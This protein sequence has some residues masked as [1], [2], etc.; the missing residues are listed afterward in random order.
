M[1][2]VDLTGGMV[3]EG[4]LQSNEVKTLQSWTEESVKEAIGAPVKSAWGAAKTNMFNQ[5]L[6][7]VFQGVTD[8]L[9][10]IENAIPDWFPKPIKDFAVTVRDKQL[11]LANRYDLL[12][13]VRGYCSAY[14]SQNINI[15]WNSNGNW[16]ILPFN[17]AFGPAKGAHI[18]GDGITFDEKGLWI[19]SAAIRADATAATPSFGSTDQIE[20]RVELCEANGT[21]VSTMAYQ[22]N[23]GTSATSIGGTFPILI[24]TPGQY[25]QVACWS[26]R[27]RWWTGG[28][29]WARLSVVKQ[30][31]RVEN[32]P[33]LDVGNET[34]N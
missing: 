29:R 31:N 24:D 11:E 17:G 2:D 19:V 3:P 15:A 5:F 32:K 25:V 4:S 6:G 1:S 14:Q 16:R 34:E 7:G 9:N 23:V 28:A 30:D 13:G 27:W 26:N 10:G 8:V 33:K 22:A 12:D 20:M 21:I 18:A